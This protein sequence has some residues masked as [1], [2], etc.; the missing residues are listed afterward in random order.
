MHGPLDVKF[1]GSRSVSAMLVIP[2]TDN[3]SRKQRRYI[4]FKVTDNF[5]PGTKNPQ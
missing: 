3:S 5:L 2:Q 4:P 1:K